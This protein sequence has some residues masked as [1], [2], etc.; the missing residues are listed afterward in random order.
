MPPVS[1]G[2]VRLL[3]LFDTARGRENPDRTESIAGDAGGAAA[4]PFWAIFAQLSF[5]ETVRFQTG[6]PGVE[7]SSTQ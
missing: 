1:P 6:R 5:S 3:F 2:G 7:A 4:Q